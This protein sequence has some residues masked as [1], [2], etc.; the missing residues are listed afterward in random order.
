MFLLLALGSLDQGNHC[1]FE[2][3]LG[4]IMSNRLSRSTQCD[5]V[6]EELKEKVSWNLAERTVWKRKWRVIKYRWQLKPM[7]ISI[8][9]REE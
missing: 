6:T 5:T 8:I 1:K 7:G 3:R 4:C 9:T 2:V